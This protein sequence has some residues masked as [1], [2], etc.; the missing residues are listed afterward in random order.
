MQENTRLVCPNCEQENPAGSHFCSNCGAQIDGMCPSCGA[1]NPAGSHYCNSCGVDLSSGQRAG[2]ATLTEPPPTAA[3]CPRCYHPNEVGSTYCYNCGLPL[4]GEPGSQASERAG[5]R[6][7]AIGR[8]AGFWARL[9]AVL[10]DTLVLTG[11]MAILLPIFFDQS[12][13]AYLTDETPEAGPQLLDSVL[14]LLY[15]AGLIA[16]FATTAGKRAFRMYVIRAD[17]TRVGFWRALGRE[18]AKIVSFLLLGIGFL[19]IAFRA[20]K[21]GL[22]DLIAD[23]AVVIR[24]R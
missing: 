6:A 7:F 9:V 2:A 12:I 4:E 18:L 21:R 17:G 5:S 19:M 24:E 20:D 23:T 11:V 10:I 14:S 22:H 8:P 3:A 16:I 15:A 13:G 1:D